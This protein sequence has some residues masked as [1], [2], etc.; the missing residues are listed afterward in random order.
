MAVDGEEDEQLGQGDQM[1]AAVA[2]G[3]IDTE[4]RVGTSMGWSC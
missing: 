1:T 4:A 2:E 3:H